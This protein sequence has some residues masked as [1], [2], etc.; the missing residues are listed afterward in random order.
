M[1][2]ERLLHQMLVLWAMENA[3]YYK[4]SKE[5]R[6]GRTMADSHS[7]VCMIVGI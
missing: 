1:G 6:T 2:V 4:L 5:V 7:V 3:E